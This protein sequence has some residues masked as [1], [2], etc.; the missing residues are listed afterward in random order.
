MKLSLSQRCLFSLL[1][2][3][4]LFW[5]IETSTQLLQDPVADWVE[6]AA[7]LNSSSYQPK[8]NQ[9]VRTVVVVHLPLSH[10]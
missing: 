6:V 2:Y 5:T 4:A 8:L 1:T 7:L 9:T 10:D 3:V